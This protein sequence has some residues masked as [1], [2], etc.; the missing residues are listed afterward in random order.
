MVGY[1]ECIVQV[2][3]T[4]SQVTT[5]T[6]CSSSARTLYRR[7]SFALQMVKLQLTPGGEVPTEADHLGEYNGIRLFPLDAVVTSSK[8]ASMCVDTD[9]SLRFH[10]PTGHALG[11]LGP[12]P[13]SHPH[14]HSFPRVCP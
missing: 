7:A 10:A 13:R 8:P 3:L 9:Q 14:T 6:S 2:S 1:E 12:H 11:R 4:P 5:T